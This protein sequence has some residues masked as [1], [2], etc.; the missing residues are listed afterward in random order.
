MTCASLE[1][2]IDDVIFIAVY[3]TIQ[4]RGIHKLQAYNTPKIDRVRGWKIHTS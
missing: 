4:A 3:A 1:C 2:P